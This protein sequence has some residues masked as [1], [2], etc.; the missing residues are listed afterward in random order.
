MK[1]HLFLIT[2][3]CLLLAAC[4]TESDAH[5][6][7][8]TAETPAD[9]DKAITS[10]IRQQLKNERGLSE[11][12]SKIDVSTSGGVVTLSGNVSSDQEKQRIIQIVR[13]IKGVKTINSS[14]EVKPA[15]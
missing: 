11:S 14:L 3:L 9:A 2:P 15:K 8:T 13:Q 6:K 1:K 12:A 4:S 10:Q 5:R 7:P